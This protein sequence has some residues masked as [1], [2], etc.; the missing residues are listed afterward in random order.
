MNAISTF[1]MVHEK[2]KKT[3]GVNKVTGKRVY[4]KPKRNLDNYKP[5]VLNRFGCFDSCLKE[6]N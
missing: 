1:S 4:I 3:Y 6:P 2:K 5:F